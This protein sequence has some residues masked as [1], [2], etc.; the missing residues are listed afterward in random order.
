MR[1][2]GVVI[3]TVAGLVA[4]GVAGLAWLREPEPITADDAAE[5]TADAL[6]DAGVTGATVGLEPS[7][8][9][10][11]PESRPAIDVWKTAANVDGGTIVLWLAQDDGEPVYLD[12][13]G[14][15]GATQLLS[16]TQS[17]ALAER[18]ENPARDRLVRQ[19]VVITIAA[20]LVLVSAALLPRVGGLVAPTT[21]PSRRR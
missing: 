6:A 19:N 20:G 7:A 15:S 12:D 3:A 17:Q 8:G 9:T 16:E 21:L 5:L 18:Q 13:R 4:L 2:I 11:E 1:R 10:Y 14:P